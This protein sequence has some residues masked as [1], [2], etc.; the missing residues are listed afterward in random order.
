MP[1]EVLQTGSGSAVFIEHWSFTGTPSLG[2][3]QFESFLL[4]SHPP[5]VYIM[6]E[7][8]RPAIPLL[9]AKCAHSDVGQFQ[10]WEHPELPGGL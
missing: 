6:D 9:R 7:N 4:G 8:N 3:I 10:V 5:S 2:G 1:G